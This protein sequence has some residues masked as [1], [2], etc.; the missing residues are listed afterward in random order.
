MIII[1]HGSVFDE[2]C[3]LL[4]LPCD[5]GGSVTAWVEREVSNYNL[6][7]PS[8][9]IP[10]GK[11]LFLESGVR[12]QK[13]NFIA[14]AASVNAK[15]LS[16]DL[17][18]IEAILV[19]IVNYSI[20]SKISLIN[21]PVL[22][23]GAGGLDHSD[24]ISVYNKILGQNHLSFNVYIPNAELAKLFGTST[25]AESFDQILK[26]SNP[27]VFIS[28]SQKNQD[29]AAWTHD[30][31]DKLIN[32]GINVQIDKYHLRPGYDLPQWMTDEIIKADKVILVCDES[33]AEKADTRK[34]GVGWETMIVQGDM[35]MQGLNNKYFAIS[36]GKFDKSLPI[37]MKSKLAFSKDDIDGDL[38]KLLGHI[39]DVDL[40]PK[41][42]DIPDW[43]KKKILNKIP[44]K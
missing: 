1:K 36:Y 22:G 41:L 13:C 26:F 29:V 11:V 20:Q 35:L 19:D 38:D 23:T 42:G 6:P 17:D 21:M 30:L 44:S 7:L 2:K 5:S 43:I 12:Y 28:Y 27:R 14:Y 31:A 18:A 15:A 4:V 32:N 16:S 8:S 40:A 3:D 37:Y 9:K 10:Y 34:A 25:E 33:Y 39:F 24:V